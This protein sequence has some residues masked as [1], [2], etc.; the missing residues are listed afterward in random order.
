[1]SNAR[2]GQPR[3]SR[4]RDQFPLT[5]EER[6]G[7]LIAVHS[8]F[9]RLKNLYVKIHPIFVDYGFKPP[10]PGVVARDLSEKIET[11]IV[12]HCDSFQRGVRPADLQRHG[13]AW[14]VKIC[15]GT[16]LTINQSKVI[17]GENYIVVNYRGNDV[18]VA[19]LWILWDARDAFFSQRLP[20]SNARRIDVAAAGDHVEFIIERSSTRKRTT[21]P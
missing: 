17:A 4:Y 1:V 11:S 14:E 12:Q 15:K 19:A 21:K 6:E 13:K 3:R 8:A 16:A 5:D 10:S 7:I 20:N 9:K 18:S 2:G